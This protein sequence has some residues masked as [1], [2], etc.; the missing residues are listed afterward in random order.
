MARLA[1]ALALLTVLI[2]GGPHVALGEEELPPKM[3][4][5]DSSITIRKPRLVAPDRDGSHPQKTPYPTTQEEENSTPLDGQSLQ[6]AQAAY[7]FLQSLPC[8]KQVW[9]TEDACG[10]AKHIPKRHMRVWATRAGRK[11]VARLPDGSLQRSGD[12]DGVVLLDPYPS[13]SWGHLVLVLFVRSNVT[14]TSCTDLKGYW[15]HPGDCLTVAVKERCRNLFDRRGRRKNY[16]RRCEINFPPLVLTEEDA[17]AHAYSRAHSPT[18]HRATESPIQRLRCRDDVI[19]YAPCA[20]LRPLNDTEHLVCDPLGVNSKRCSAG[21]NTVH[22]RC[23][24]FEVCDQAVLVSG[25][26]NRDLSP[27]ESRNKLKMSYDMLR[28]NGFHKGNIKIFYANGAKKNADP[29]MPHAIYPS[30]MKLGFRYHLRNLCSLPMCADALLLYLAGP[31]FNDGTILLWDEDRNGLVRGGEVY[32]PRE[33]LRDLQDCTARQ[34]TLLVD[35]SYAGEIV[36][37]FAASKKHKN[38]QVYAAGGSE[39]YSWGREFTSHWAHYAHTHSCT[40]HVHQASLSGVHL[41]HPTSYDGSNGELQ[42]T[43]FGAPCD[44]SPPFSWKE[45]H[46]RYLGCQNTPTAIWVRSFPPHFSPPTVSDITDEFYLPEMD[47]VEY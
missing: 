47:F 31:S 42:R 45:L 2:A 10:D 19:G 21:H 44:V 37:A 13:A 30:S 14:L 26:W 12:H 17:H 6:W 25:G 29:E 24:L 40:K 9:T 39:D 20:R 7:D 4:R 41:S 27:E 16:A 5:D 46:H 33:I 15:T 22:T 18:A 1:T 28:H 34:V 36:K 3:Q 32:S 43:I 35:A 23:R 38:V 11:Y 8:E